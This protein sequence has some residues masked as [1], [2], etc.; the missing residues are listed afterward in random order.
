M[1][2]VARHDLAANI[3]WSAPMIPPE[4][5]KRY[6]LR[7][8]EKTVLTLILGMWASRRELSKQTRDKTDD[9]EA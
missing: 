2:D 7:N 9:C 5:G 8:G 3:D 4:A 6:I 1:T